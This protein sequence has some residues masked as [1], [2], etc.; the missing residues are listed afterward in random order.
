MGKQMGD[1]KTN[2]GN[3]QEANA[4]LAAAKAQAKA[5]GKNVFLIFHA[6]WCGPCFALRQFLNGP[7]VKPL[8]DSHYVVLEEDVFEKEKNGWENP[9]G[10]A[11]FK[12]YGGTGVIPFY[13]I[14]DPSGKKIG[15][16]IV[17][18]E[19]MGMPFNTATVNSFVGLIRATASGLTEGELARIGDALRQ[20]IRG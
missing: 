5:Q 9:G 2:H 3:G 15:D 17:N 10:Q 20:L 1:D 19:N 7:Q 4:L 18:S 12:Q 11:L 16:S 13:A 8:I 6:S 14:L